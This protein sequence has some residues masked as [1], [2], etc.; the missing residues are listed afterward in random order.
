MTATTNASNGSDLSRFAKSN[1]VMQLLGY[2]DRGAFWQFVRRS[3]L[4]H[5]RLNQRRILFERTALNAWLAARSV[6]G[7]AR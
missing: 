6:G 5:H 2:G 1:E 7:N 3:G 4:P